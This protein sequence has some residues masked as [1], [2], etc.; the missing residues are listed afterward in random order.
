MEKGRKVYIRCFKGEDPGAALAQSMG[1]G[2]AGGDDKDALYRQLAERFASKGYVVVETPEEADYAYFHVWPISNGMVFYQYAMPVI[3][4]VDQQLFEE[5][6][7]NRSQK[8]TG[9]MVPITTLKDVDQIKEISKKVHANGGKV[10]ATCVVCNPWILDKLEPYVDALTF[11]YTISPVAM[12]NALGAQ[13]DVLSGDY[14]PTGKMSLTMVSCMDVIRI[15]EE[16]ID[17]VVREVCASPN[18]VPGYDKD[19]YIDPEILKHV[20]GGSYAYCDE[21]GNYYRSGFGLSY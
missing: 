1:A 9:R 2:V 11:Q 3:E 17:G 8:K 21:D 7:A 14:H 4:M 20:K 5:R 16:E 19:Q 15:T 12:D 10:I 13:M 6:E 18:D